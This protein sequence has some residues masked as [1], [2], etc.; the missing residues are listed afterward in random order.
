MTIRTCKSAQNDCIEFTCRFHS[1]RPSD[2]N[3]NVP[4]QRGVLRL[5]FGTRSARGNDS[6]SRR[7]GAVSGGLWRASVVACGCRVSVERTSFVDAAARRR[8]RRR[9]AVSESGRGRRG[10]SAALAVGGSGQGGGGGAGGGNGEGGR[11]ARASTSAGQQQPH[12]HA[13]A[14]SAQTGQEE[15]LP[16]DWEEGERLPLYFDDSD[17]FEDDSLC[18]WSSE[19]ESLWNNWRGWRR[20]HPPHPAHPA[21]QHPS[22]P[23]AHNHAQDSSKEPISSLRKPVPG[24]VARP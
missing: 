20:P 14:H 9:L 15:L 11:G 12:A 13:S 21:H 22:H 23:H 8:R 3:R 2:R 1:D 10:R 18:S 6:L 17:R 19:P 24:G 5:G 7:R 4:W 16:S